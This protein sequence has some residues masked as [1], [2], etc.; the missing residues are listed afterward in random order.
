M[1]KDI[2]ASVISGLILAAIVWFF[3]FIVDKF[4]WAWVLW[5]EDIPHILWYVTAALVFGFGLYIKLS[6]GNSADT[7]QFI[8]E[9]HD[10]RVIGRHKFRDL[11]WV[12][13]SDQPVIGHG[14][15]NQDLNAERVFLRTRPQCKHQNCRT[16]VDL[17]KIL[18]VH[19][20]TCPTCKEKVFSC[21]NWDEVRRMARDVLRGDIRRGTIDLEDIANQ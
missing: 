18:W 6:R 17:S 7:E 19:I 14:N 20:A 5:V 13:V 2:S 21:K 16:D 8:I 11:F 4:N 10:Y 1:K 15:L 3:G 9:F 12:V